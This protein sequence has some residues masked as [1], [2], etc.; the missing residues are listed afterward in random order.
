VVIS[1]E[2]LKEISVVSDSKIVM[3][4]IDGLGG[5]PDPKTGKTELE[6]A[7]T[8]KFDYLARNGICGLSIPVSQGITPGSGA[9]HLALFG[10]DPLKFTIG[11][12]VLEAL[13][14]DFELGENDIAARGNFCSVDRSGIITDRRA[15]RIT[16][17]KCNELCNIL[18]KVQLE[19]TEFFI[20]P[21]KEHRFLFVLR[22][23][24]MSD[25]ISDTD[26][27]KVGLTPIRSI[28]REESAK[29]TANL[30]N[31]FID[32]AVTLLVDHNPANMVLLRGF[33]RKPN[34]PSMEEI[35]QL[36]PAAIAMY[37][38]YRGLAKLI[39]M[40][41]FRA[42]DGIEEELAILNDCYNEHDF[43]FIHVKKT[44]SAGE[45]GN[46]RKKVQVIEEVDSVLPKLMNLK[47]DVIVVTGDH[48]T[49]AILKGHSWHPVP[50]LLYSK[51]C[52]PDKVKKFSESACVA[53]SLG[54]FFAVDIMRLA[55]A[56]ALKLN[57]FGA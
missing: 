54:T 16:T 21:V 14:V 48:S 34:I 41:V 20:Q 55:M 30:V 43:F 53:G 29:K 32:K 24:G 51:W 9:G 12:G 38:M 26:P 40:D 27:Q 23:K 13:G 6:T 2:Q 50:F 8:P 46:F 18:S 4:V 44:D 45:D 35:Y 47:P 39:G 31:E 11:R 5:L 22:G 10:Y 49:P 25:E 17:D 15:G 7:S 56:N 37:P 3:L 36:K 1:L 57:K 52:R 28:A 33:S 19:G 42:T